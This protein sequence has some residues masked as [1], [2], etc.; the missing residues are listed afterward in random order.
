MGIAQVGMSKYYFQTVW[1]SPKQWHYWDKYEYPC[2][3]SLCRPY[4][5]I[6][7]SLI[8]PGVSLLSIHYLLIPAILIHSAKSIFS[9]CKSMQD[10]L[11]SI[12]FDYMKYW[13]LFLWLHFGFK[14]KS[15]IEKVYVLGGF[16]PHAVYL[17]AEESMD[18]NINSNLT[19]CHTHTHNHF[20]FAFFNTSKIVQY[21]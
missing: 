6:H 19:Q 21:M 10:R 5:L 9:S 18:N 2:K 13:P 14:K 4:L 16:E 11:V 15:C 1:L 7:V 12:F 3:A 20:I 8:N 17:L